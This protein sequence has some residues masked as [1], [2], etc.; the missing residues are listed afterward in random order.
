MYQISNEL[1]NFIDDIE[2]EHPSVNRSFI[3][4]ISKTLIL[5]CPENT[6]IATECY[7][8]F[9]KTFNNYIRRYCRDKL[10]EI[11]NFSSD[12][13]QTKTNKYNIIEPYQFIINNDSKFIYVI[14]EFRGYKYVNN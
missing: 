1:K 12:E 9:A 11:I 14:V 7:E 3:F 4:K 10:G 5:D 6:E 13:F 8:W 2:C